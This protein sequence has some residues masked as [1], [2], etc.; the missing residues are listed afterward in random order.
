LYSRFETGY[1]ILSLL[2]D[3]KEE[4]L[5]WLPVE[6]LWPLLIAVACQ[7]TGQERL[8]VIGLL[9]DVICLMST[10]GACEKWKAKLN[11]SAL[12]P[13]WQLYTTVI[14]EYGEGGRIEERGGEREEMGGGGKKERKEG[15]KRIEG[16]R[17]EEREE[18]GKKE[19]GGERGG[20]RGRGKKEGGR[21]EKRKEEGRREKTGGGGKER[22]E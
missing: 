7:H 12:K 19:E 14:K 20:E 6:Q 13:L 4:L 22:A 15:R 9:M 2:M 21:G 1:L 17:G 8:K 10:E 3:K 18:R 5:N 16:E 11:L